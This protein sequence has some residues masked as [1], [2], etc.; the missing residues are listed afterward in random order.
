MVVKSIKRRWAINLRKVL[1]ETKLPISAVWR[2]SVGSSE[3]YDLGSFKDFEEDPISYLVC[4]VNSIDFEK[5]TASVDVFYP[6]EENS[7]ELNVYLHELSLADMTSVD[8]PTSEED[9]EMRMTDEELKV[10][11]IMLDHVRYFY[12]CQWVSQR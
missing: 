5:L 2:C 7:R 6:E 1:P 11:N 3:S 4:D 9:T 8:N 12:N 10:A